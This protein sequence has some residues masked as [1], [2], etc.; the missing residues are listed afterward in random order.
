MLSTPRHFLGQQQHSAL[1]LTAANRLT[2]F[3]PSPPSNIISLTKKEQKERSRAVGACLQVGVQG[4]K[5]GGGAKRRNFKQ[6]P[7]FWGNF[8]EI[9]AKVGGQLPPCPSG[10][11]SPEEGREK[12]KIADYRLLFSTQQLN[13]VKSMKTFSTIVVYCSYVMSCPSGGVCGCSKLKLLCL[14]HHLSVLLSSGLALWP[15]N[16]QLAWLL[17]TQL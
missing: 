6:N 2:D 5:G 15:S 13:I 17:S 8:G 11:N 9:L 14:C 4:P 7:L 3:F 1:C 16:L 10:S 12:E